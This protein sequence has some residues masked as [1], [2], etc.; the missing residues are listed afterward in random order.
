MTTATTS[1]MDEVLPDFDFRS[2]H[3]RHVDAS[4]G[5]VTDAI[6]SH[7]LGGRAS[8]LVRMRGL[9]PPSG[10]IREVLAR[11]G[12]T[13]LAE[14]P[15]LEVVAGINGRFWAIREQAHLEAPPDLQAFRA[16]D[17]PGWAQGAISLRVEPLEGG[18]TA[19]STETRVRCVDETARRRFA[20][21]WL[22]IK[23][24]SGWLRHDLL[25]RI[26]RVAEGAA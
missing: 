26:A 4:L 1:L 12:F 2:R 16:F 23:A 7:R 6:E 18:T 21:Y 20:V 14:R 3:S 11:S 17:R 15:G 25:A 8:L 19:L 5:R 24:F 13:V 10:P 9:H 22:L